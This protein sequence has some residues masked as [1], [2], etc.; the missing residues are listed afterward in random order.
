MLKLVWRLVR[1]FKFLLSFPSRLRILM[2]SKCKAA[3]TRI[4]S[5]WCSNQRHKT[6]FFNPDPPPRILCS[7]QSELPPID[8]HVV[9][10]LGP[11]DPSSDDP[12]AAT[13]HGAVSPPAPAPAEPPTTS[14]NRTTQSEPVWDIQPGIADGRMRSAKHRNAGLPIGD[15][16]QSLTEIP[17]G[18]QRFVHPDGNVLFYHTELHV[19]SDT[20]I[21]EEKGLADGIVSIASR[22]RNAAAGFT[23]AETELVLNVTASDDGRRI[24]HYYF[25]DPTN[26]RLWWNSDVKSENLF[27]I[28][29][30]QPN[31]IKYLLEACYWS[32]CQYY[33]HGRHFC[34]E[35]LHEL[36]G[37]LS[38]AKAAIPM[39]HADD[40]DAQDEYTVCTVAREKF[41]N[42]HG[43]EYARI[44]ADAYVF[45]E[46]HWEDQ[47][48]FKIIN[49]LL[50]WSFKKHTLRVRRA[51]ADIF[52]RRRCKD[53]VIKVTNELSRCTIFSTVMLTAN[54]AFLT[55]PG[56]TV[57]L[58]V[59]IHGSALMTI[60]SIV[61]SFVLLNMYASTKFARSTTAVCFLSHSSVNIMWSITNGVGI[62]GLAVLHSLPMVSLIW[63]ILL[64][65]V[66]LAYH[67][68]VQAHLTVRIIFGVV[69][70]MLFCVGTLGCM[71]LSFFA[72]V[73]V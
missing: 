71:I 51:L 56:V 44:D 65:F 66:A 57:P 5:L 41:L 59:I 17:P 70:F 8:H 36:R 25:V 1:L 30:K 43:Q 10:E 38:Y 45:G 73:D 13:A 26:R 58:Q 24:C 3:L 47:I 62:P 55:V 67:V 31:Q 22:L 11:F 50:P 69:Y 72:R 9:V 53:F 34:F 29:F 23:D 15:R 18:W 4:A 68:F 32:H 27:G 61:V 12:G 6:T 39:T 52:I 60:T 16:T 2:F 48:V 64:F 40:P 20:Y 14:D 42:F 63:S 46:D 28:R 54:L 19:F 33:P 49:W 7:D 35:V 37:L 21:L